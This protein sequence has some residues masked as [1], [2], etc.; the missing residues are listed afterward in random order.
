ML[1][2]MRRISI[3]EKSSLQNKNERVA[4]RRSEYLH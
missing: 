3:V 2:L 1:I 4:V